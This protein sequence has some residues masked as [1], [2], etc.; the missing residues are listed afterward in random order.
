M[1]SLLEKTA[2]KKTNPPSPRSHQLPVFSQL[3]VGPS[4]LHT[5]HWYLCLAWSCMGLVHA[6]TATVSSYVRQPV[7]V[8]YCLWFL[9]FF[10]PHFYNNPECWEGGIRYRCLIWGWALSSSAGQTVVGL[11]VSHLPQDI[12]FIRFRDALISKDAKPLGVSLLLFPF[13]SIETEGSL[14]ELLPA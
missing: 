9:H 5:S 1:G 4:D 2:L 3:G 7:V 14:W 12:P 6:D 11:C 8:T 13:R 10:Y